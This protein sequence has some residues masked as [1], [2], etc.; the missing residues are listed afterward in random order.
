MRTD[1]HRHA[2]TYCNP[3]S[4]MCRG[5]TRGI[6]RVYFHACTG[7]EGG[8]GGGQWCVYV[9]ARDDNEYDN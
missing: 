2:D 6:A 7:M 5:L 1:T 9:D 3:R 8:G 4:R